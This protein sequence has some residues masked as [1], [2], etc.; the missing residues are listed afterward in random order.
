L[1]GKNKIFLPNIDCILDPE[2]LVDRPYIGRT[3]RQLGLA[4]VLESSGS[5]F[6]RSSL[7]R[8]EV[9]I[10]VNCAAGSAIPS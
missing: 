10:H 4:F 6:S 1:E 5:I 2:L 8:M 3:Y 7:L 9:N